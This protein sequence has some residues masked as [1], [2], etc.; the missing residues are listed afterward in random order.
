MSEGSI[1]YGFGV[2][3]Q[4]IVVSSSISNLILTFMRM[5]N[6]NVGF[7]SFIFMGFTSIILLT[8]KCK[9]VIYAK[10]NKS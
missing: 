7:N 5:V 3:A 8:E 4:V 1:T 2:S 9:D 10:Q 6:L